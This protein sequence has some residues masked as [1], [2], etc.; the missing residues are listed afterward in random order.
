MMRAKL[1]LAALVLMTASPLLVG[2]LGAQ[3]IQEIEVA[4]SALGWIE[5]AGAPESIALVERDGKTYYAVSLDGGQTVASVRQQRP[6]LMLRDH[7]FDP[8]EGEPKTLR[9][10]E[11]A[12]SQRLFIVQ[13]HGQILNG[14]DQ[15]LADQGVE[16]LQYFPWQARL[17]R[18]DRGLLADV[19]ALPFVRWVGEYRPDW[20]LD[21]TVLDDLLAG[22]RTT[23]RYQIHVTRKGPDE[24]AE[25][26]DFIRSIG[27]K[28][29]DYVSPHGFILEA[30]LTP[31]QLVTLVRHDRVLFVDPWSAPEDDLDIARQFGGADYVE[32]MAG[33]AGQ[34]VRG[35]VQDS[36][37]N[38]SHPDFVTAPLIHVGNSG[39][40]GHGTSVYGVVFGTGLGNP[41][42][43]GFLPEA[44]PV[45][46]S[47]S[48]IIDRYIET[49][50]LLQDPYNCV[51]QTNSW[52][53]SQT[54]NYTTISADMDN[55]LFDHDIIVTQSQSNTGTT[56]SRPQAW[57][58][59]I[60]SVGGI[61]H[62]NTLTETDDAWAGGAS[63][64]PSTDGRVKPDISAFYDSTLA[65][66]SSGSYSNFSGTSN[67]TPVTA[68]HFGIIF[69]MWADGIF[70][71]ALINWDVFENKPHS[72]TAKALMLNSATQYAFS[73]TSADLTRS[74]QGWGRPDVG[75]LYDRRDKMQIIDHDLVLSQL[76]QST[77]SMTVPAGEPEFRATL[78]FPDPPG[79][80]AAS[81]HRIN[82]LTL[83]VTAPGGTIYWG[84]VGLYA[85]NYSQSGGS[86][87][88]VDTV[89]QVLVQ[90]PAAGSWTIEV[91]ATE[92]IQD[93]HLETGAIDADYSLVVS[94]VDPLP[95]PSAD[96][97]QA[98]QSDAIFQ[99][100]DGVNLNG[101]KPKVGVNG[102]FF[103]TLDA[104][105]PLEFIW[106]GPVNRTFLL[107]FGPLN[108]ANEVF[109][110]IGNLDIG[111]VGPGNYADIQTLMNGLAPVG[112]FD[113][114]ANTGPA[115]KKT[116]AVSV[117][118]GLSGVLGGFQTIFWDG[119][120]NTIRMSAATEVTIN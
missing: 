104:G 29:A 19:A 6:E 118:A 115:G 2:R 57:A 68:G 109:P 36:G 3:G 22:R 76:Q 51:F 117:P 31:A 62:Y 90:N 37:L 7:R 79:N 42:A 83:K 111:L 86:A 35:E 20:R 16:V 120:T 18:C 34:G 39:S 21:R 50:E 105:D 66:N 80:P 63:I 47:Y 97:G 58:K 116:L 38:P 56:A 8:L 4:P 72:T 23:G 81:V 98:N 94:G 25:V 75:S 99:I 101:E 73:G 49:G 30:D 107:L 60:V 45:F 67:A 91:I 13:F 26:V 9:G 48:N 27:G 110:G 59:N 53:N 70:G 114:L 112:F 43:R 14:F 12:A 61:R 119:P 24:K 85:N 33:Y 54:S 64:G 100:R 5:V 1:V 71:N 84:N 87:N 113:L 74:H 93:G 15:V 77:F 103:V 92:V 46:H 28:P 89:E 52:G 78:I 10:F 17:V 82:D 44:Q 69:Q 32:T 102:P 96:S 11:A 65:A 108:R 40:P 95:G 88:T 106:E 55:I 41:Q